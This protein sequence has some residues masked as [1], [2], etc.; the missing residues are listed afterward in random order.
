M[1]AR[2]DMLAILGIAEMEDMEDRDGTEGIDMD[3]LG[4]DAG[5]E[6]E[7]TLDLFMHFSM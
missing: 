2:L 1:L 6:G 4:T 3:W 5:A 7:D